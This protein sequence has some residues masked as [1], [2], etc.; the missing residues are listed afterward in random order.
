MFIYFIAKSPKK[1][2]SHLGMRPTGK[3]DIAIDMHKG[4]ITQA[5][6]SVG[7]VNSRESSYFVTNADL[8]AESGLARLNV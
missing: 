5:E 8:R 7:L 6:P 2:L 1:S 3:Q 4:P